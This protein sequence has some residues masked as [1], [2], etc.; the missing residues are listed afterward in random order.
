MEVIL[1]N[2]SLLL[3]TLGTK[4]W[5]HELGLDRYLGAYRQNCSHNRAA[6]HIKMSS[7]SRVITKP[8]MTIMTFMNTSTSNYRDIHI[9]PRLPCP[10]FLAELKYCSKSI[11]ISTCIHRHPGNPGFRKRNRL[12]MPTILHPTDFA[13]SSL[14]QGKGCCPISFPEAAILLV[15]DGDRDLWPGPTPEVR[16]SRTSRHSAHAQSQ[17]WQIWLVL[18][19]IYRPFCNSWSRDR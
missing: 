19:S 8:F 10:W 12:R 13:F 18:V 17:V 7:S 2:T 1:L 14:W 5:S 15:S 9:S 6:K 3:N 11:D 4:K 16:D